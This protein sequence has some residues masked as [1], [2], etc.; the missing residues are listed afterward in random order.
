MGL[1]QRSS[2]EACLLT[3]TRVTAGRGFAKRHTYAT[4]NTHFVG[5]DDTY[6]FQWVCNV[7]AVVVA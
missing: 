5:D 3:Q 2:N 6:K 7:S 1:R 4:R